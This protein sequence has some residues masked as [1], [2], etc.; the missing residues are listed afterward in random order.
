MKFSVSIKNSSINF[1]NQSFS[2]DSKGIYV[3]SGENGI[4]KTTILKNIVFGKCISRSEEPENI[5]KNFSYIE[6][7]PPLLDCTVEHYL[8][9]FNKNIDTKL[10]KKLLAQFN[11]NLIAKKDSIM[12]LSGGELTKLNIISGLAKKSKYIFIDEPTN[13][14]DD[15]SVRVF[16]DIIEE[17]ALNKSIII[18]T[19]DKRLDKEDYQHLFITKGKITV[20]YKESTN[21][22]S[23]QEIE[24]INYPH[25]KIFASLLK[26]KLFIIITF[27]LL[28]LVYFMFLTNEFTFNHFYSTEEL[29][30][31]NGYVLTYAVDYQYSDLNK[32]YAKYTELDPKI[33]EANYNKMILYA[34]IPN[35]KN[36]DNVEKVYYSNDDY[37]NQLTE[38]YY[39]NTLLNEL[40]ILSIPYE[41]M[42]NYNNILEFSMNLK[43][44]ISGTLPKDNQNEVVLSK[45]ILECYYP[46]IIIDEA[47]GQEVLI[48]NEQYTIVGIGYYDI[49][50]I[51]YK[52][53][54]MLGFSIY[55]KTYFNKEIAK[56]I[57]YKRDNDFAYPYTP[58]HVVVKTSIYHEKDVL[59]SL[60]VN[61]PANNFYSYNY[62]SYF[63]LG[64]NESML[65]I[66][67]IV[68]IIASI[69][70]ST[71]IFLIH[72]KR[73][74]LYENICN[75]YDNYYLTNQRT[76][77]LIL[78][79]KIIQSLLSLLFVYVLS[80]KYQEIKKIMLINV[81][82]LIIPLYLYHFIKGKRH[83]K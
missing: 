30:S 40:N 25:S 38:M 22:T 75:F 57:K 12:K 9:R 10:M 41:I 65:K 62:A 7:D 34:D 74:V 44:M 69:L 3:I 14:L 17:L 82:I 27:L 21:K 19:H 5:I 33:D 77:K 64:I 26:R 76:K 43:N 36:M 35:I 37:L 58:N 61:F 31:N 16:V 18:V 59:D 20:D 55:D 68:N 28:F 53:K 4:G 73:F 71:A 54:H 15:E 79:T 72:I 46:E 32:K 2:I 70:L 47:I 6:Q 56:I 83:G 60:L 1:E 48:E 42:V 29:P 24:V 78:A 66:T 8:H 81:I 49:C 63:K 67:Y 11:L 39:N 51:S 80:T 45:R 50:I 13:N 23:H 52:E